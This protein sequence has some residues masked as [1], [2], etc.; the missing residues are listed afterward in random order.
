MS[1]CNHCGQP[2]PQQGPTCQ[3]EGCTNPALFEGWLRVRDGFGIPTGL[4]QRHPVCAYH[5]KE[6]IAAE[7]KTAEEI[8][9]LIKE[10]NDE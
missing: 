4:I 5:V 2:L 1:H 6:L 7:G 9:R 8:E 10:A 3:I